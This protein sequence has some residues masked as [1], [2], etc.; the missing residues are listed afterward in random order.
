MLL[1]EIAFMPSLSEGVL[2][3]LF[4]KTFFIFS[5]ESILVLQ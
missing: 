4:V 5:I 3:A 2:D 1:L